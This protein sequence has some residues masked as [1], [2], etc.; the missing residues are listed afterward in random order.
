MVN[1]SRCLALSNCV[2]FIL[3]VQ[4]V[5]LQSLIQSVTSFMQNH[6]SVFS[7]LLLLLLLLLLSLVLLL[8]LLLLILLLLLFRASSFISTETLFSI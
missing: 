3:L 5:I 7:K 2:L 4:Y 1:A 8:L 6:F